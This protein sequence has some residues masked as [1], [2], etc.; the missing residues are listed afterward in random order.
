MVA[1]DGFVFW[2]KPSETCHVEES[3]RGRRY[4]SARLE[5]EGTVLV[6]HAY[7]ARTDGRVGIEGADTACEG[8]LG[9]NGVGIEQQ[10]IFGANE[11]ERHVVGT[12]KARV[13]WV[14]DV[15]DLRET[16][17][18]VFDRTV[19]TVVIDYEDIAVDTVKGTEHG[20]E[21]LPEVVLY[22]IV[23]YDDRQFHLS[24]SPC[25]N[26]YL[27]SVSISTSVL[28][29]RASMYL[30]SLSSDGTHASVATI[31]MQAQSMPVLSMRRK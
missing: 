3:G 9:D 17:A 5:G 13:G 19:L 28:L 23:D 1:T 11:P 24:V 26:G 7:S 18:K 10:D 4:A 6:E 8:V 12:G 25:M 14:F 2:E 21:T 31:A 22:L 15:V 20:V 16:V 27:S 29:S 30:L